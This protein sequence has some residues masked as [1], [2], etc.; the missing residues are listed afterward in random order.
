MVPCT[1]SDFFL[2]QETLMID[3][4]DWKEYREI[5]AVIE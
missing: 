1:L 4:M 3:P 2:L 5:E